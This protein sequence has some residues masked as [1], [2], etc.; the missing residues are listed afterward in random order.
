M[1]ALSGSAIAA[2]GRFPK[3]ARGA[4]GMWPRAAMAI[5]LPEHLRG[6][7]VDNRDGDIHPAKGAAVA[8][9]SMTT[10]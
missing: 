6:R 2:N 3:R 7:R 9:K 1:A 4:D 8:G 5:A 10:W